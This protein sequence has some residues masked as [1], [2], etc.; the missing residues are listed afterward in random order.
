MKNLGPT[1]GGGPTQRLLYTVHSESRDQDVKLVAR[2]MAA[3]QL[4]VVEPRGGARD[5][6]LDERV[7][8]QGPDLGRSDLINC[9]DTL[10]KQG[11]S[12]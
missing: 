10:N 5:P 8:D 12:R 9:G 2:Q 3:P 11:L 4:A 1:Q 7:I 6:V